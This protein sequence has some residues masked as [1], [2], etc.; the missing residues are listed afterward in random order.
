MKILL[1]I[2]LAIIPNFVFSQK[3]KM[4]EY[5]FYG[6]HK[7]TCIEI[8]N[9]S[10]FNYVQWKLNSNIGHGNYSLSKKELSL[11]FSKTNCFEITEIKKDLEVSSDSFQLNFQVSSDY[12]N[13][14]EKDSNY[15]PFVRIQLEISESDGNLEITN[16]ETETDFFGVG[17]ITIP[18]SA[19]RISVVVYSVSFENYSFSLQPEADSEI[20]ILLRPTSWTPIENKTIKFRVKKITKNKIILIDKKKVIIEL[21]RMENM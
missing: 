13:E 10:S 20:N 12:R 4:G 1:P 11:N 15:I 8:V 2:I 21:V 14:K 3:I 6:A 19:T 5:C 16:Y 7:G 9:D 18:R 17:Q